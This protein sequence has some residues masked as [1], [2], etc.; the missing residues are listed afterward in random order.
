MPALTAG[1]KANFETLIA[2]VTNGDALLLDCQLRQ[3]GRP[4]A[5]VCAVNVAPDENADRQY[6]FV[7]LAMLF[8]G[9]PYELLAPP[10]S[11]GG[12]ADPQARVGR[13]TS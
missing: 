2:A 6:E 13:N 7:P 8:D 3:S 9:N 10:D 12:Y 1:H 4:A 11:G 5:V